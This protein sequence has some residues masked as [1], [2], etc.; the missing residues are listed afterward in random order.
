MA[1]YRKIDPYIWNDDKFPSMSANGQ[2][3]CL[4]LM[5]HPHM[6]AV[7]GL[8]A[9]IVGVASEH[10]KLSEKAFRE[11]FDKGIVKADKKAPLIWFPKFLKYNPPES[12]NVVKAWVKALDYLPECETKNEIILHVKDFLEGFKEAFREAFTKDLPESGAG[13][14]A[15]T[16]DIDPPPKKRF[17]PPTQEEVEKYFDDNGYTVDSAKKAFKYYE[18][19]NWKDGRGNQVKNWKQKMQAVWFKEKNEKPKPELDT[20]FNPET[21]VVPECL[22]NQ[23]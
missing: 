20:G 5:T 6:T 16:G 9:T 22:Q 10:P 23:K 18:T 1:H 19:G 8:R 3:A 17:V 13:A 7:G 2:L 11:A 15:G 14:G 21:C 12:P 4:F